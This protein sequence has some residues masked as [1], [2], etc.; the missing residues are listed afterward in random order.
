MGE[1]SC[2]KQLIDGDGTF[3]VSGLESFMKTVKLAECGLSYAVVAIMGPQS[4]G[5]S[6]LLNHLFHT[7][8]RE[9][10]TFRRRSQTTKG[11]WIAKCV[12]IEPCTIAMDLEGTDGR[13]RG[14]DDTT[15]EKQS[16]LFALATADILLINM[17]CHDIGREQAANKPLLKTVFQVMM[18][19]FSPRKT[20]LLFVIRDKTKTPLEHLEPVLRE[21]IQKIWDAVSKPKAHIDTPL[22]E[23]FNVEVTALSS[24]EEKEE[25][26]KEQ[27]AQLRQRFFHSIAPGRL[28]GDRRGV[29]PASAFSFSAQQIWK[30]IRE[31]KDLDLPAHKVMVATVRCDE[32]ANEKLSRLTSDEGWLELE[33]GVQS[34]PVSGFGKK[35]SSILDAYLSE[36]DMEAIYFDE[37]VRAAKRQQLES[38]ALHL[39]HP[40]YQAMLGHLRSKTLDSFKNGLEL[41]LKKGTGF[42]ASVRDCTL[43]CMLEF[44]KGCSD[45]A[46]RQ[47]DWDASKACD[48]LRRDIEAHAASVR[49]AKLSE[50][51]ANYEKQLTEALA[52]PVESL[53]DAAGQDTWGSIRRLLKRETE[54]AVSGFSTALAGFE[55]DQTTFDKMVGNLVDFARNVVEKKS[56]EEAGKVLNR[57]TDRFSTVFRHDNDSMPRVWTGKEDIRAITKDARIVAL[58]LLSVMA[59]IRLDE[60]PDQIENVLFS[61]LTDGTNA[62]ALTRHSTDALASSTWEEVPPK[63]TLI[64]PVQCKSLW[65]QLQ[66]ETEYTVTQ[67]ISVQ[68][69]HRRG[70]NGLP[71]PWV[72]L[73]MVVLG[74]NEFMLI[75]NLLLKSPLYLMALFIICVLFRALWIQLHIGGEFRHG[76]LSG[77]LSLL[78]KIIPTVMNLL[79]LLADAGPTVM[80]VLKRLADAGQTAMNLLKRLADEGQMDQNPEPSRLDPPSLGSQ[81]FRGQSQRE[82]SSFRSQSQRETS[83]GPDL[84]S[85]SS[86]VSSSESGIEYSSSLIHR[87]VSNVGTIDRT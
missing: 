87:Q 25:Q 68:E 54:V 12:G 52:E 74:F 41:S 65:T 62:V 42:A 27:V 70:N 9:M 50:L 80:N 11:I 85:S 51:V 76:A 20:I 14:E 83:A 18:R 23:F 81:S 26:F 10:D 64:S 48:K 61:S 37:G 24:Y 16:A 5:K 53:F 31:N 57:M 32:I 43:S 63:N 2:S 56:R 7:N 29:V 6:T 78:S 28:A 30:V 38:K 49:S 66:K 67:A 59:A 3:N 60:K 73:V 58:K 45:V 82:T 86:Q 71:S 33:E 77:I 72:I 46:I 22:S 79:K 47:A 8:F 39:V 40:A 21:D 34:G 55:L 35:L 15:F 4:S 17:W 44:D 84:S 1:D 36:Y 19:L 75:L 13:E 69:A